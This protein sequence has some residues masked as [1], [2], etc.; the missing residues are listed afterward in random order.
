[1]S[2]EIQNEVTNEEP[3]MCTLKEQI[4]DAAVPDICG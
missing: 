2:T 4:G 1:M 3:K